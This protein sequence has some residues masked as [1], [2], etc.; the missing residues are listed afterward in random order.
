M[1]GFRSTGLAAGLGDN[2]GTLLLEAFVVCECMITGLAG[3]HDD[4]GS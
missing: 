2:T 4:L 3:L 1:G